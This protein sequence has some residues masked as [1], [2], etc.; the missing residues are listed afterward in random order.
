[1]TDVAAVAAFTAAGLSLVNVGISARLARQGRLDQWRRDTELPI[2]AKVLTLSEECQTSWSNTARAKRLLAS[3]TP[4]D[5]VANRNAATQAWEAGCSSL[6]RL[7]FEIAQLDLMAG[8]TLRSAVKALAVPHES[9]ARFLRPTS[10]LGDFFELW[11]RESNAITHLQSEV[12]GSA[13]ADLRIDTH[14]RLF[15]RRSLSRAVS[16][17]SR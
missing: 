9:L 5:D 2:V 13:R 3:D 8:A 6:E 4:G 1:V 15:A 11:G 14:W 12:V 17:R 7:R 16:P 10:G